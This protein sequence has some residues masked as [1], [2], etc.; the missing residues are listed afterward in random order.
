MD[1]SQSTPPRRSR[2]RRLATGI[3]VA[4]LVL[5][6]LWS[7][8]LML[9]RRDR[10]ETPIVWATLQPPPE[11]V[12]RPW[13]HIVIHHSASDRGSTAS[14]D[15]W[16]RNGMHWDGIGYHFVIGNGRDMPL[17]RMD[18]TFRWTKQ[19]EGA[20]A[21]GGEKGRPYNQVGIGICIIGDLNLHPMDPWQEERLVELCAELIRHVP[22]LS[23]DVIIGHRD[24]PGKSTECPGK[25]VDIEH[26]RELVRK[27]LAEPQNG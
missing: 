4:A 22:T 16:H 8:W 21:G 25:T 14:I 10:D 2:D 27:R 15:D 9:H 20:H 7:G 18:A 24:V 19:R 6:A 13:A 26:I 3:A 23:P 11:A 12:M 5:L 1:T 17:G